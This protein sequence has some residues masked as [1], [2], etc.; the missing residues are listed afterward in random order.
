M[1]RNSRFAPKAFGAAFYPSDPRYPR[2]KVGRLGLLRASRYGGGRK[3]SL[4]VLH[5]QVRRALRGTQDR[6]HG[7]LEVSFGGSALADSCPN[8]LLFLRPRITRI[9]RMRKNSRFA[10]KAF[11]AASI[12]LI[13]VIRGRIRDRVGG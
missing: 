2:W 1:R 4:P 8:D 7:G 9:A 10:P 3:T 6:S 13:R 11:G 5:F 12:R